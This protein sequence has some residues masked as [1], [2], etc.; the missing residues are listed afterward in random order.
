MT[1]DDIFEALGGR[2]A[3]AQALG[4]SRHAPYNW[5]SDG[6]PSRHWPEIVLLAAARGVKGVSFDVLRATGTNRRL[7]REPRV[8]AADSKPA[9]K[10]SASVTLSERPDFETAA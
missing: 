10:P 6:I 4:V 1:V 3:L 8:T 7:A 5:R 2:K 9:R